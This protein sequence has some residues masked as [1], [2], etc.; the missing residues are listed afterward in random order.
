[1]RSQEEGEMKSQEGEKQK[2]SHT[3]ER[4]IQFFLSRT[5]YFFNVKSTMGL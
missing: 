4:G 3:E 2:K 5:Y 1:M